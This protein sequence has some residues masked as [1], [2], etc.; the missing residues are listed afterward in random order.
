VDASARH[1]H[2]GGVLGVLEARDVNVVRYARPV[3]IRA[4]PERGGRR[5]AHDAAR[6]WAV[7]SAKGTLK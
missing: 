1:T 7:I 5:F 3:A 4:A 6:F 2:R